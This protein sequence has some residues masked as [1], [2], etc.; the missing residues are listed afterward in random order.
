MAVGASRRAIATLVLRQAFVLVSIGI[1][2]GLAVA[3]L[4]S[5]AIAS[6]LYGVTPTYP[7]AY[8]GVAL[9]FWSVGL[10]AAVAPVVRATRIDPLRSLN[11]GT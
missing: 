9:L 6:Q 4:G 1:G 11:A 2:C 3:A 5:T 8:V 10:A 7:A